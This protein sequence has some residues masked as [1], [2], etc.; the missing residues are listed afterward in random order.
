MADEAARA[1]EE[2]LRSAFPVRLALTP[3]TG[4]G[5]VR[6]DVFYRFGRHVATPLDESAAGVSEATWDGST[7]AGEQ[8]RGGYYIYRVTVDDDA[9]SGTLL[10]E[11]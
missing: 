2:P 6:V 9:E 10:V 5:T 11:A 8:A 4:A 3:P 7:D 1:P